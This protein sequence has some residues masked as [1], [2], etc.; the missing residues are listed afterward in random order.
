V[1]VVSHKNLD[2]EKSVLE[3]DKEKREIKNLLTPSK[4]AERKIKLRV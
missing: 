3:S 4:Q 2:I 1:N